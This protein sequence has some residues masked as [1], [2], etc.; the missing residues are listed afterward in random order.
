RQ[1][2]PRNP[3]LGAIASCILILAL[4]H[5]VFDELLVADSVRDGYPYLMVALVLLAPRLPAGRVAESWLYGVLNFHLIWVGIALIVPSIP[6]RLPQLQP[7]LGIL[8]PRGDFDSAVCGVA[9]AIY[10]SAFLR[11]RKALYLV[12]VALNLIAAALLLSRA[13]FVAAVVVVFAV[14]LSRV[15]ASVHH[16]RRVVVVTLF[17]A[18]ALALILASPSIPIL[19]RFAGSLGLP[20]SNSISLQAA[21]T[22]NARISAWPTLYEYVAVENAQVLGL[23]FGRN[24]MEESG[25]S[26]ALNVQ[27]DVRSPH[28]WW[29]DV[30]ARLGI[31]GLLLITFLSAIGFV[32]GWRLLHG[33]SIQ[34]AAGAVLIA[35][36]IV[37]SLGVIF[38]SP[39]GA[40][41]YFFCLGASRWWYGRRE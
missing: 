20:A 38:E 12:V 39:F 40:V 37:A 23:G 3:L 7:G 17:A 15:P 18:S 16:G 30:Y 19:Q 6:T 27:D 21:G 5:F 13:G 9:A 34:V 36:P 35:L 2:V 29:L 8:T 25:A 11:G 14:L 22:E 26:V 24:I 31:V 32:R 4:G 33:D 28:N 1:S 10:L 41:P